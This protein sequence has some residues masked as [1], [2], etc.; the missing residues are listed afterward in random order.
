MGEDTLAIIQDYKMVKL[1]YRNRQS[2]RFEIDDRARVLPAEEADPLIELVFSEKEIQLIGEFSKLHNIRWL[3]TANY[4]LRS[5]SITHTAQQWTAMFSHM[6]ALCD[7]SIRQLAQIKL[8]SFNKDS[9]PVEVPSEQWLYEVYRTIGQK[10]EQLKPLLRSSLEG[11]PVSESDRLSNWGTTHLFFR[12]YHPERKVSIAKSLLQNSM[13]PIL[14]NSVRNII[15]SQHYLIIESISKEK[16]CSVLELF[17]YELV[18]F[19]VMDVDLT[20]GF[21]KAQELTKYK[22]II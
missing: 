15:S 6:F 7:V 5:Y 17:N 3:T 20:K 21:V 19:K 12:D 4:D 11:C 18:P 9:L 8:G 16:G 13:P 1:L 22:E 10:V 2:Q 14:T